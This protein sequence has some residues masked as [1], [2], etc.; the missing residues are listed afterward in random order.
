MF[1]AAAVAAHAETPPAATKTKV[2]YKVQDTDLDTML[3]AP[4]AK[5]ILLKYTPEIVN[6][7]QIEMGRGMTLSQLQQFAGDQLTNE[8]LAKIQANLDATK[9]N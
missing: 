6:N 9:P 7:S 3:D 2:A 4:A 5:A 1:L 8:K